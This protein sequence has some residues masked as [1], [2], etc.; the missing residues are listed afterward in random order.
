MTSV[1]STRDMAPNLL[2]RPP[3][4]TR[5][6][7]GRWAHLMVDPVRQLATL[8]DLYAMGLLSLEEYDR[9]K[10]HVRDL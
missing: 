6:F 4:G 2:T 9:Y 8:A 10:H 1:G 5:E 3:S 7:V